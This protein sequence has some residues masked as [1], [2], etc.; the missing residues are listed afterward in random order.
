MYYSIQLKLYEEKS[1]NKC[2]KKCSI[3]SLKK[4]IIN[5]IEIMLII[6][7]CIVIYCKVVFYSIEETFIFKL[8]RK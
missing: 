2:Y 3:I 6:I 4:N 8:L 7:I 5:Y 1:T